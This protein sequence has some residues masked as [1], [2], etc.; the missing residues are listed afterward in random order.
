MSP[1]HNYNDN[2][3][4]TF[5]A[6]FFSSVNDKTLTAN[7]NP[8]EFTGLAVSG[9]SSFC[10]HRN[11]YSYGPNSKTRKVKKKIKMNKIDLITMTRGVRVR[12]LRGGCTFGAL[13]A[14]LAASE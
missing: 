10:S 2:S 9:R 12:R 1:H 8:A 3:G 4:I 6:W 5:R 13:A 11:L 14:T 7:Q